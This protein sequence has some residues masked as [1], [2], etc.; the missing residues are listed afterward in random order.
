MNF[1]L[2]AP[3]ATRVELLLFASGSA[4]EPMQVVDLDSQHHRSGEHWHVEVEGI[5][6]GCCYA[7]RVFGAAPT[8]APRWYTSQPL[9]ARAQGSSSTLE[10][11]KPWL[12][13]SSGPNT[14]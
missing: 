1:S 8:A 4:P 6:I 3:L 12:P 13:G 11:L 14:R 7:Y 5:G 9:I 10:G 2:A